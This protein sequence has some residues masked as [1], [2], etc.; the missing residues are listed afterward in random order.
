M[1]RSLVVKSIIMFMTVWTFVPNNV[2][3]QSFVD[4]EYS[5]STFFISADGKLYGWGQATFGLWSGG[6]DGYISEALLIP[7]PSDTAVWTSISSGGS[8]TFFITD[9]HEFY[10]C[11]NNNQYFSEELKL[12]APLNH[13]TLFVSKLGI[14]KWNKVKLAGHGV[15]AISADGELYGWGQL[16]SEILGV[17]NFAVDSPCHVFRPNGVTRWVDVQP[18]VEGHILLL[19]D[20]QNLYAIGLNDSG[21]FG[22]GNT[23]SSMIPQK[24]ILPA[25]ETGWKTMAVSSNYTVG[26]SMSGHLYEWG[27]LSLNKAT[28]RK[29]IIPQ[30]LPQPS[31]SDV[32]VDVKTS[33]DNNAIA[34]TDKGNVFTWGRNGAGESGLGDHQPPHPYPTQIVNPLIGT[35]WTAIGEG[36]SSTY[37]VDD[38]CNFYGW[39]GN[40]QAQLLPDPLHN[41]TIDTPTFIHNFCQS[42]VRSNIIEPV[43]SNAIF[44]TSDLL[45]INT[46]GQATGLAELFNATGIKVMEEQYTNADNISLNLGGFGNGFYSIHFG[47]IIMKVILIK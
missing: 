11:G 41:Y 27:Q 40:S 26:I 35:K 9:K 22:N 45:R 46:H 21:Q 43:R 42:S 6:T 31:D 34:L 29:S 20:D 2:F 25:G 38:K 1:N 5:N 47:R 8:V 24:V 33:F 3:S 17:N 16:P 37:A 32:W 39:G 7:R 36:L 15:I 12:Q 19:G 23:V 13:P 18:S 30:L 14:S 28:S 10:I 4:P 44:C